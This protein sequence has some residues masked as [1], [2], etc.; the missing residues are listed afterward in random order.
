MSGD[1]AIVCYIDKDQWIEQE[2]LWLL[3]SWYYSGGWMVSDLVVFHHPDVQGLPVD[4]SIKYIPLQAFA[5]KYPEWT[6]YR[7]INSIGYMSEP[8]AGILAE[9]KYVLRTDCDCFLTPYFRNF[10]PRLTTFGAG[11]YAETP[12]VVHRLTDIAAKWGIAPGFNNIGSTVMGFASRVIT[13]SLIQLEFCKKLREEEFKD[14]MGQWPGWWFGTLSMYAG[15]LAAWAYFGPN[16]T[17][18]GLDCH[19]L[20]HDDISPSDYHIHAWHTYEHFSKFNWREGKYRGRDMGSLDITKIA[21]YCLWIA[22]DGP[23]G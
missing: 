4:N 21:D 15:Q 16:M 8:E 2:F 9:Y 12:E 13:Y 3:K 14:G 18:G 5:D 1:I 20:S 23:C 7:F 17:M 10:R 6:G 19:C 11:Q 22:G